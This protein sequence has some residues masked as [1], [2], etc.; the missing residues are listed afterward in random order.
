MKLSVIELKERILGN[1]PGAHNYF[2]PPVIY[3]IKTLEPNDL[4]LMPI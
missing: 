3:K 2:P 4:S 1:V